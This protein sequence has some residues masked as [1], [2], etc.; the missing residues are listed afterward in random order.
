MVIAVVVV[1]ESVW[2]GDRQTVGAD[3]SRTADIH[4]RFL[5]V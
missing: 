1:V 2:V 3:E 5:R 4:G